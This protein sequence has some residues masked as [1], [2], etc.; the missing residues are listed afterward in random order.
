MASLRF[1]QPPPGE[2]FMNG[3]TEHCEHRTR[4]IDYVAGCL[5][6]DESIALELH[7]HRCDS[8]HSSLSALLKRDASDSLR[9][10]LDVESERSPAIGSLGK[11]SEAVIE[12]DRQATRPHQTSANAVSGA[13]SGSCA[14][15]PLETPEVIFPQRLDELSRYHP[16][17]IAGTGGMGVVWEVWD[18][19]MHRTVAVKV[20][21]SERSSSSQVSRLLHE[22]SALARLS[23]PNIVSVYELTQYEGRLAMV[24]EYVSGT[25]LSELIKGDPVSE[26]DATKLLIPVVSAMVHAHRQ[27]VIHRDLK[28]SN[29][30]ISWPD[31]D[32][33]A[34]RRISDAHIRVSDFGLARISD[35]QRMTQTGQV[36]GT[37]TY[38]SPEQVTGD[39]NAIDERVDLY[40]VGVILYELLTGRPPF[41]S[42]D[43]LVTMRMIQETDPVPLRMLQPKLSREIELV[44]LKCL[45]KQPAER[46]RSA[47]AL[48]ADLQAIPAGRPITARPLSAWVR[49]L[50]WMN[51]NRKLTIAGATTVASV[52]TLVTASLLFAR[53]QARLRERAEI[54]EKTATSRTAEV[55]SMAEAAQQSANNL[56]RQ[57]LDTVSD[58]NMV[59]QYLERTGV[60]AIHD[61]ASLERNGI[62]VSTTMR[63]YER[64]L[65]SDVEGRGLSRGDLA[66]ALNFVKMRRTLHPTESNLQILDRISPIIEGA[67]AAARKDP[68]FRNCKVLYHRLRAEEF[69]STKDIEK[70]A[71][72]YLHMADGIGW[73]ATQLP[74]TD[75]GICHHLRNQSQC[76]DKAAAMFAESGRFS[77]AVDVLTKACAVHEQVLKS[78]QASDDDVLRLLEL[79]LAKATQLAKLDP[80]AACQELLTTV[81]ASQKYHM[82]DPGRESD[83]E[84]MRSNHRTMLDTLQKQDADSAVEVIGTQAP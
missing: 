10:L 77:D 6:E 20:L 55:Q 58:M 38:M 83:L 44:I 60:L 70:A 47:Q 37:P 4:L 30:L 41:I 54:A 9:S 57:L 39:A 82:K 63:A 65:N 3:D 61:A 71:A 40:A 16:V 73:L 25:T 59:Q 67:K 42:D 17:R 22:A 56:R 62:V 12:T 45:S 29:L 15:D 43:P 27:G 79:R 84:Q 24:M 14:L 19:V 23:H 53:T 48:L 34:V 13:P 21:R 31:E 36:L 74:S 81:K 76:L 68:W 7:L 64:Y 5:S 11:T 52:I 1:D 69:T 35:Q 18:N 49:S 2:K 50:R 78:E 51:R 46:Y 80:D 33:D 28:P 26:G 32:A 66:I 75:P 72:E 8:C